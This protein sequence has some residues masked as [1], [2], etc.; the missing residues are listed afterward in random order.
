MLI[1]VISALAVI[2]AVVLWRKRTAFAQ[3]Q[4]VA[5]G[6]LKLQAIN[7]RAFTQESSAH[8]Y[9]P[10]KYLNHDYKSKSFC[11]SMAFLL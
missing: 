8:E 6:M 1:I 10:N 5:G 3:D 2:F 11:I 7:Y 9:F 4:N